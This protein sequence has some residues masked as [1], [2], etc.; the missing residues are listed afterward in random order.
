[1]LLSC[2]CWQGSKRTAGPGTRD[3]GTEAIPEP[4]KMGLSS[5]LSTTIQA[6]PEMLGVGSAASRASRFCSPANG[7]SATCAQID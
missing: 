5:V 1:M 4:K 6:W 7:P 2:F 3:T